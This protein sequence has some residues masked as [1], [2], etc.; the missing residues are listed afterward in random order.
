MT[1]IPQKAAIYAIRLYQRLTENRLSHRCVFAPTCSEYAVL[2][3]RKYG[4]IQGLVL[5]A[6]R[7]YRC[8]PGAGG[9]DYP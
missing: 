3:I 8:R 4:L 5:T 7:L 1:S 9:V 6:K 2:A